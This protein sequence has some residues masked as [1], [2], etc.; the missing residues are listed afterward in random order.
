MKKKCQRIFIAILSVFAMTGIF[1][2][3]VQAGNND[4]IQTSTCGWNTASGNN[5]FGSCSVQHGANTPRRGTISFSHQ[6]FNLSTSGSNITRGSHASA[7]LAISVNNG[8]TAPNGTTV[9][10]G[11][12]G[13]VSRGRV[14]LVRPISIG[15]LGN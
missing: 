14:V 3:A 7:S 4:V 1:V 12:S 2:V 10:A 11:N 15:G 5:R 8:V 6:Q 9:R 13:S